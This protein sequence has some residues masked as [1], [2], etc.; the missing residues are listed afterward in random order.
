MNAADYV[1][2]RFLPEERDIMDE[3]V[4]SAADGVE[5]WIKEGCEKAMNRINAA[6]K[7]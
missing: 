4:L 7:E 3:A 1:L 6:P 5:L 2:A